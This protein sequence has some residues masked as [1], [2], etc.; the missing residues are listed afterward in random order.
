MTG[1]SDHSSVVCFTATVQ[2]LFVCLFV[3]EASQQQHKRR[4]GDSSMCPS[5]GSGCIA[6]YCT[7][8]V[9]NIEQVSHEVEES[10]QFLFEYDATQ[11][12]NLLKK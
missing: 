10:L 3:F 4:H 1:V 8:F 7:A 12:Q 5:V 6:S 9:S 11:F 2:V